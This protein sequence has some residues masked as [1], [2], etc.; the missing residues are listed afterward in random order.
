[1][2]AKQTNSSHRAGKKGNR[3]QKHVP[4]EKMD[5]YISLINDNP[6]VFT[7]EANTCMLQKHHPKYDKKKCEEQETQPISLAQVD[8]DKVGRRMLQGEAAHGRRSKK[9]PKKGPK[10]GQKKFGEDTE[11][12]HEAVA[13]A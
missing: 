3:F 10:S 12:F 4:T 1:M 8:A 7:W 13:K 2:T 5:L 9:V 11:E 6:H